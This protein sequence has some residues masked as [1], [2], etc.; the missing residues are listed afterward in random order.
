MSVVYSAALKN[1]RMQ[2]VLNFI[3]VAATAAHLKIYSA[4]LVN[5]IDFTLAKPSFSLAADTLTLLGVPRATVGLAA[6]NAVIA[7]IFDGN[8]VLV[9]DQLSVGENQGNI[10][11]TSASITIGQANELRSGTLVHG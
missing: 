10:I 11:I 3:D 6:G 9:V 7:K 4:D 2:Q 8:G 5:L 1:A